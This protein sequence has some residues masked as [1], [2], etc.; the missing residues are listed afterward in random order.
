MHPAWPYPVVTRA[1]GADDVLAA[2]RPRRSG[3]LEPVKSLCRSRRAWRAF[4]PSRRWFIRATLVD[5]AT[6]PTCAARDDL[7]PL[8]LPGS[9]RTR[10][11]ARAKSSA[12]RARISRRGGRAPRWTPSDRTTP[13]QAG[14][15]VEHAADNVQAGVAELAERAVTA[16]G[17]RPLRPEFAG[18]A[19]TSSGSCRRG[20]AASEV[21]ERRGRA[22]AAPGLRDVA[23]RHPALGIRWTG[24]SPSGSRWR[25]WPATTGRRRGGG[26][27]PPPSSPAQERPRPEQRCPRLGSCVRPATFLGERRD[28]NRDIRDAALG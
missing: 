24:R 25:A 4:R 23:L 28:L 3:P 22:A 7:P 19:V 2:A 17:V 14:P 9:A 18:T 11:A 16:A 13:T 12:A 20:T 15:V 6:P 26:S 21:P 5:S 10:R 1:D 8:S 27:A